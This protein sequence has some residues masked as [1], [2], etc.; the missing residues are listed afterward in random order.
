M[1]PYMK[2]E[3]ICLPISAEFS[4]IIV[5]VNIE[6]TLIATNLSEQFSE[7][8]KREELRKKREDLAKQPNKFAR[9]DFVAQKKKTLTK[10]HVAIDRKKIID[11][12]IKLE[13][14]INQTEKDI[15]DLQKGDQKSDDIKQKEIKEIKELTSMIARWKEASQEGIIELH[16]LVS[17][18]YPGMVS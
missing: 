10:V 8:Q 6:P 16:K 15:I 7:L 3:S 12:C 2:K 1:I 4:T 14:S 13:R 9:K 5:P 17:Q 18:Q 11:E